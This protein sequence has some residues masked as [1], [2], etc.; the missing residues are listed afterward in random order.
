VATEEGISIP[1]YLH[2]PPDKIQ[3]GGQTGEVEAL[4]LLIWIH[5]GGMVVGEA[6]DGALLKFAQ[7]PHI[8]LK[9]Y[10]TLALLRS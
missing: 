10:L 7:V 8:A 5:G 3:E 9:S 2:S 4:P 1:I 6:R